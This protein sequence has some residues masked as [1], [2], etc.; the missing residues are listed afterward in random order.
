MTEESTAIIRSFQQVRDLC[1]NAEQ[2]LISC[3]A[4]LRP[5]FL[6]YGK[7][8]SPHEESPAWG[9]P[10]HWVP[11]RFVRHFYRKDQ[12]DK[13]VLAVGVL[14]WDPGDD[15]FTEPLAIASFM[16]CKKYSP[17]WY[18]APFISA[19]KSCAGPHGIVQTYENFPDSVRDVLHDFLDEK[20]RIQSIA[21]PLTNID[22]PNA[23][24][25]LLRPLLVEVEK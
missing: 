11:H 23:L 18:W 12:R 13:A 5:T 9:N 6:S 1:R 10:D 19:W 3:D 14:F 16:R 4:L 24:E 2:L 7:T 17:A 21:K 8:L 15:D 22:S 25:S 20:K